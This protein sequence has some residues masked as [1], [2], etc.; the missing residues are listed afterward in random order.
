MEDEQELDRKDFDLWWD[1]EGS[2]AIAYDEEQMFNDYS[3]Q[4]RRKCREAWLN[5]A[6]KAE[7]RAEKRALEQHNEEQTWQ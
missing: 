1:K 6:M 5:G 2:K 4:V 3:P 7:M